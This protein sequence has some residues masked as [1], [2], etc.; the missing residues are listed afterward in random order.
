MKLLKPT[1][2]NS[3]SHLWILIFDKAAKD[4]QWEKGHFPTNG[5]MG[6]GWSYTPYPGKKMQLMNLG[7]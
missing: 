2:L 5:A 6:T 4:I 1:T 3:V 7:P